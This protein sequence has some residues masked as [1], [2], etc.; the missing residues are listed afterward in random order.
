MNSTDTLQST[1]KNERDK[2][3]SKLESYVLIDTGVIEEIN[4]QGRARVVSSTFMSNKP[5]IYNNAEVIF[6]GNANGTFAA[7]GRNMACLI[8]IPRSCMPDISNLVLHMG[9]ASYNKDGVK[10]MPIGNGFSNNVKLYYSD[11]GNLSVLAGTY[12]INFENNTIVLQSKD[13]KT[14]VS[15]DGKNCLHMFYQSDTGSYFIDITEAGV[16]H[17]YISQG[18]DV[19]WTDKFNSDGSRTFV[20]KD[21]QGEVL[22]SV[23]IDADGTMTV[24]S[25]ADVSVTT[26]GNAS[27]QAEGDITASTEDGE[28]SI[29][30]SSIKLNG[31]DRHL[32]AYEDLKDAMDK[33]YTA[34]T[35]TNIAGDGAPQPTWTGLDPVT[36][37]DISKAK[38]DNVVTG[39][40]SAT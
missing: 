22:S 39:A 32:V 13:G 23:T 8:F 16:V 26:E 29:D 33:L 2:F 1:F 9:T 35:T 15:L 40:A 24:H 6:P 25:A 34:L 5:I 4:E 19:I 36:K 20:Q 37:I 11:G 31:D 28:V 21:E 10:A 3:L 27:V 12:V 17:E 7:S 14:S 38:V 18:S 30:A